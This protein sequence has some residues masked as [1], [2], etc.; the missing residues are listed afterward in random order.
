MINIKE[1]L[2]LVPTLPGSYQMKDKDGH[3][4]YVGKAKNL[5][6]RLKSYFT[7]NV[8]GKTAMLVSNI[9]DFDYIVTSSELESLI[10]EITLIKKY[11]PK[12]NI[13]LKDDKSY[14]Y[15]EITSEKYPR[16][17]VVRSISR[18]KNTSKLYGPYPN[19]S[20]ARKTVDMLNRLYPLR[21]CEHLPKKECLYYHIH[22][23][24][25]YCI[26]EVDSTTIKN[27][28]DEI[29]SFL[30]GNSKVIKEKIEEEMLKASNAMNYERALELKNMLKDI[31]IT[32]TKQKI[33]L[34][35]N[36]V[37]D[38]VSY[39]K[40]ENYL[41]ITIFFIRE[42]LLFGKHNE[43]LLTMDNEQDDLLQYLINFYEKNMHPKELLVPN[44]LDVSLLEDYLK[45]K[46]A[47]PMRG[48]LKKLVDLA[49][50]NSEIA[51]REKLEKLKQDYNAKQEAL[52]ELARLLHKDTVSR[53]ECFDNSH[54]FGTFYVGGMVVFKDFEPLKS[55]YRKFKISTDVKDDLSAM[56]EVLYRRYYRAIMEN[57]V[58]P[59]LLLMDGGELQVSVA[60]EIL[61]S[62]K[63][64]IPIIGL[65]KD[66]KHR[67][68]VVIDQDFNPLD[69]KADSNLFLYL[70]RIQ[71]EVHRY[72][73]TYHR[74]LK[75]KGALASY[76]D[77]IEG[78]GSV[79]RK[80]LLKRFSSLKKM[81][82]ASIEE[83]KEVVSED[84]AKRLYQAL[85]ERKEENNEKE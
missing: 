67:T 83:L 36:Y 42:G 16:L 24:L 82:E 56:K 72:A 35:H 32:L 11:T 50:E 79:R 3:I 59:D 39:T 29:A 48:D 6:N 71:D 27:M 38:V 19:V 22:E 76:L 44:E 51:L 43:I 28:T 12:Y 5:R 62:L 46:I 54:L 21:K 34:H 68:S 81:K 7:K 85:H 18:K 47:K 55:E 73:I 66:N 31:D 1:K 84:V 75:Q 20:A 15:I 4:I 9:A 25:G 17:R 2:K 10:L 23:C 45:I 49:K 58:L 30:K 52:E 70:T 63:L 77:M 57:Q 33:D 8:S 53:M 41:S 26:K 61:D 65:K 80:E 13:L 60:K 69:I 14:P 74:N 37:L 64:N 40:E 78:I